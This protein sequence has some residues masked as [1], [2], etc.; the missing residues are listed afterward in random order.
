[1]REDD[2]KGW[3]SPFPLPPHRFSLST[4]KENQ[5]PAGVDYLT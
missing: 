4:P 2:V 3:F 5:M 1:M